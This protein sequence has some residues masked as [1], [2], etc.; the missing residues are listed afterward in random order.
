MFLLVAWTFNRS[1]VKCYKSHRSKLTLSIGLAGFL[2]LLGVYITEVA[3]H[4]H[5]HAHEHEGHNE[6]III[7]FAVLGGALL[8]ISHILNISKS[9]GKCH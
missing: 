7:S 3:S 8:V 2:C 6:D 9:K 4:F 1:V 5:A